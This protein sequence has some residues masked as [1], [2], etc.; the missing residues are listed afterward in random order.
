MKMT[1]AAHLSD[2][3]LASEL[4]RLAGAE[5]RAT[6]ALIV[7]LAEFDA[8]RLCEGQGFS[9][10]FQYCQDVLRLSE[11]AAFNRIKAA[12]L[13]RRFPVVLEMLA[14]GT[15]SPTTACMLAPHINDDNHAALLAEAAGQSKK[16]VEVL[17][18]RHYPKPDVRGSVRRL[19]APVAQPAV[20]AQG[21][22]SGDASPA[23]PL[24][25]DVLL[26]LAAEASQT[27]NVA[28]PVAPALVPATRPAVVRPLAPE[29]YEIRFTACAETREALRTAQDLLAHAVPSGDLDQVIGRALKLLVADLTRRKCGTAAPRP[30]PRQPSDPADTSAAL[31]RAVWMR[32]GGSCAYVASNGRR[33]GE[34]RFVEFHHLDP[35][36][37][38]GKATVDRIELRCGVHNRHEAKLFYGPGRRYGG[39]PS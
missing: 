9:S 16:D 38:G 14:S 39:A 7:H 35:R 26:P 32:D 12:R 8:R 31:R 10:T 22:G 27:G 2:E 34:R 18:A 17:L 37:A 15:L 29:R 24:A 11:D 21:A 19:P 28:P 4:S 33:C 6:V 1:D 13:A 30:H 3:V 23:S 20:T 36:A 25:H 5:R